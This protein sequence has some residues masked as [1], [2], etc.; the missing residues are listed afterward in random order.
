MFVLL[1]IT[2]QW[3]TISYIFPCH[4]GLYMLQHN[5]YHIFR[6]SCICT[7]NYTI[8]LH[9]TIML[10]HWSLWR[11]CLGLLW[12]HFQIFC[13]ELRHHGANCKLPLCPVVLLLL[14]KY[15]TRSIV[16]TSIASFETSD[17]ITSPG[18]VVRLVLV[19]PC[20][21]C[22][23]FPNRSSVSIL[24]ILVSIWNVLGFS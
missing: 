18:K 15:L 21:F 4:L 8:G 13:F 12:C 2:Y 1:H 10:C 9:H 6:C 16:R 24:Q 23:C 22:I 11:H 17:S 20:T 3:Y 14:S 5:L 19:T 7:N